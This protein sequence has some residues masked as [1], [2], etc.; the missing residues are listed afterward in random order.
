MR[1]QQRCCSNAHSTLHRAQQA[2]A[3]LLLLLRRLRRLLANQAAFATVPCRG[4]AGG[5]SASGVIIAG[6]GGGQSVVLVLQACVAAAP[7]RTR[8]GRAAVACG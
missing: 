5:V 1:A 3:T 6:W 4:L 7:G 2:A 8:Q